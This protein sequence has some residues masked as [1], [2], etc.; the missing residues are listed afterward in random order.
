MIA[1]IPALAMLTA[2]GLLHGYSL[3]GHRLASMQAQVI[4]LHE[5]KR[6]AAAERSSG[7]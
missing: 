5:R 7:I 3:H 4:S 2:F 6:A 1:G